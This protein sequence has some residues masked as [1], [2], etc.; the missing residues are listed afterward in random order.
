[1]Q[2]LEDSIHKFK[3]QLPTLIGADNNATSRRKD[4]K[5]VWEETKEAAKKKVDAGLL[6]RK[7]VWWIGRSSTVDFQ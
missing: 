2:L 6:C 5:A 3:K 7:W 1:M 4:A